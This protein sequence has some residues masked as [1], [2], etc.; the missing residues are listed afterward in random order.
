MTYTTR[1]YPHAVQDDQTIKISLAPSPPGIPPA[2]HDE[3]APRTMPITGEMD[4]KRDRMLRQFRN[5]Q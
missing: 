4:W 5:A 1:R 2:D 3:T